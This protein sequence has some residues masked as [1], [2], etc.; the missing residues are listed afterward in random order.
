MFG[1]GFVTYWEQA[2]AKMIGV[3]PAA[4]AKYN[5]VSAPVAAQMALGAAEAAGA[6]IAVSVTGLAGPNG[7]DAV[8][9]FSQ[10]VA[11]LRGE[12]AKLPNRGIFLED[13]FSV[14][15]REYLQRVTVTDHIDMVDLVRVLFR[16]LDYGDG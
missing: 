9:R 13:Q 16:A 15:I 5:V 1:F 3:D 11:Y 2:K 12:V 10:A 4:I 7:G 6:D 14:L 8:R